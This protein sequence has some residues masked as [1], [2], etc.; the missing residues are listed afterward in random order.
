MGQIYCNLKTT[1]RNTEDALDSIPPASENSNRDD[2]N[3]IDKVSSASY[4]AGIDRRQ[5][6]QINGTM[7][8]NEPVD[9]EG[10]KSFAGAKHSST[11][12]SEGSDKNDENAIDKVSSASYAAGIEFENEDQVGESTL[13]KCSHNPVLGSLQTDSSF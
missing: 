3:L 8:S 7:K 13:A 12:S 10:Y 9:T 5:S 6:S 11:V 1:R 2:E 4:A